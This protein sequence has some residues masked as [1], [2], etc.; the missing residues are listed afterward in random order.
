MD[1]LEW[2]K[3]EV[4]LRGSKLHWEGGQTCVV[5]TSFP[6][7]PFIIVYIHKDGWLYVYTGVIFHVKPK[8]RKIFSEIH[9]YRWFASLYRSLCVSTDTA[10]NLDFALKTL[11]SS[12]ETTSGSTI[13]PLPLILKQPPGPRGHSIE[14]VARV[15]MT[16]EDS[17]R[18]T[19]LA[20]FRLLLS[21]YRN[22]LMHLFTA[23]A[24]LA[25][26]LYHCLPCSQG[27]RLPHTSPVVGLQTPL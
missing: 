7:H 14:E 18:I 13:R 3:R 26:S 27:E 6:S 25:L 16:A 11:S 9:E 21:H 22:Q 15:E 17:Q 12:L 10:Q 1:R 20:F 8:K 2:L 23:E 5:I 19:D 4:V 24:M